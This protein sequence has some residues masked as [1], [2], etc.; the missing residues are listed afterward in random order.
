MKI[1]GYP[2]VESDGFPEDFQVV[3][4]RYEDIGKMITM[5]KKLTYRIPNEAVQGSTFIYELTALDNGK[6]MLSCQ[7]EWPG[8]EEHSLERSIIILC[9]EMLEIL[10]EKL[11]AMMGVGA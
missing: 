7:T 6:W 4:G 1:F 3:F 8:D 10:E 9:P 11:P 5:A 2:V